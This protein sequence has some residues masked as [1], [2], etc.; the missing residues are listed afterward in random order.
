MPCGTTDNLHVHLDAHPC[1][2][3]Q[4]A[5]LRR[6][7]TYTLRKDGRAKHSLSFL[8]QDCQSSLMAFLSFPFYFFDKIMIQCY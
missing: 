2:K 5:R 6:G 3:R 8:W 1:R 4:I 7:K